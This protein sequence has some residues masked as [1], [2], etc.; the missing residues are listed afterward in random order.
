MLY[1]IAAYW[2]FLLDHAADRRRRRLVVPGPARGGRSDGVAGAGARR[3]VIW[4]FFEVWVLMLAA[5][6]IGCPLG[7][8]AYRLIAR[9]PA[10][11]PAGRFCRC[12][13]RRRRR[14]QEP[15]RH[16]AGLAP[17]IPPLGRALGA[18]RTRRT[19]IG[20]FHRLEAPGRQE[21]LPAARR[22][23]DAHRP[24]RPARRRRSTVDGA[25]RD[26]EP[27]MARADEAGEAAA[28]TRRPRWRG[29]WHWPRRA[30]A[31]RTI[32]SASAA[33]ASASSSASIALG[34]YH[35]G[36]IAAWTPAEIRWVAQQL[37]FP[38]RI[39]RDDWVGQ[40]IVLAAG[41]DTG[42]VKSADRRRA[43]RWEATFAQSG[44]RDA[45]EI[46]AKPQATLP[47]RTC[48]AKRLWARPCRRRSAT[49]RETA[50]NRTCSEA[51]EPEEAFVGQRETEAAEA[52]GGQPAHEAGEAGGD[53]THRTGRAATRR[54]ADP[55]G[56]YRG[57]GRN[58]LAGCSRLRWLGSATASRSK[59]RLVARDDR[60]GRRAASFRRR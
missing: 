51:Q 42:F 56:R 44:A 17:G 45:D 3:A 43:R 37:A 9:Q 7:A 4:H 49:R 32:C 29:R 52:V 47:T 31:C 36:Q 15:A 20:S 8:L 25:A 22:R 6:A 2:P 34:I 1:V 54:S 11:R 5:F 53:A 16:R 12:G 57:E 40:A 33:S 55:G 59:L 28:A 58:G 30:M 39:E 14:H 19:I 35:F 23:A 13:R 46:D 41:G 38:D 27:A 18:R 24:V 60:I 10:G 48:P 26:G 21:R 50:S